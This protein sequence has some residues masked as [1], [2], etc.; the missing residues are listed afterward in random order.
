[1]T[2]KRHW[3][4]PLCVASLI[5]FV[6]GTCGFSAKEAGSSPITLTES[7]IQA[8]C[9]FNFLKFVQWPKNVF[10]RPDTPLV[11]GFLGKEPVSPIFEEITR[12]QDVEGRKLIVKR[13]TRLA[14]LGNV[15]M[16]FVGQDQMGAFL[17]AFKQLKEK[18]ILTISALKGF[19]EKGGVINFTLVKNKVRFK[20]NLNTA[21]EAQ[22]KI[23]SRLLQIGT[24]VGCEPDQSCG[25]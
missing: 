22:L 14:D 17:A 18:N 3:V 15:H 13:S 19:A 25:H 24:I 23:S 11:V 2:G 9:L 12:G 8:A 21:K 5:F 6:A 7:Q 10:E 4:R 20:I 1:M 16:L